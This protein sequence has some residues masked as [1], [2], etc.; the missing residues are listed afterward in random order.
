M[1]RLPESS[2]N[3]SGLRSV[4]NNEMDLIHVCLDMERIGIKIDASYIVKAMEY[5]QKELSRAT[6][7]FEQATGRP[8][9]DSNKLFK[10]IFT[11]NGER[12]GTTE[13]GNPSFTSNVLEELDSPT[14]KQILEI[15][16]HDKRIGTFYSSFLYYADDDDIIRANCRQAGTTTGRFSYSEP[17]LQQLPSED[18]GEDRPFVVRR[19]FIPRMGKTFASID[20]QAMEYRVFLDMA[21][22]KE[23]IDKVNQ[24]HDLHQATADMMGVSRVEAKTLGFMLLYGGGV[25]KLALSL[26]IDDIHARELKDL[27]FGKLPGVKRL[28]RDIVQTSESRGY[29]RN[30]FGRRSWL[31]NFEYSYKMPNALVQGTCADVI[32]HAMV[33]IH[34]ENIPYCNMLLTIHDELLFEIDSDKLDCINI[35]KRHME[36]IYKPWN[37]LPMK[38]EAAVSDKSLAKKDL[39]SYAD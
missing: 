32:K 38:A 7:A 18:D 8:F 9:V 12:Y 37:G 39:F 35:I 22:E 28:I 2:V 3:L 36:N 27:Y 24:G 29:I 17:N 20:F 5:E 31:G 16:N 26:G 6:A 25:K 10:E 19:S 14:A 23:L 21:G 30:P 33:N 34:K 4:Y 1:Q 15:R 11:K 13:K